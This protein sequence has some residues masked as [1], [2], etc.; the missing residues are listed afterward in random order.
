MDLSLNGNVRK[1]MALVRNSICILALMSTAYGAEVSKSSTELNP[2]PSKN[3]N[4]GFSSVLAS[5]LHRT[6]DIDHSLS[7]KFSITPSISLDGGYTF[8][9][10]LSGTKD[11]KGERKFHMGNGFIALSKGLRKFDNLS[12]SASLSAVIPLAEATKDIQ[13]L[14]TG[15]KLSPKFSYKATENSSLSYS[16]GIKI[17]FHEYKTSLVGTSNTQYSLSQSA[18]YNYNAWDLFSISLG[19]SYARSFTYNGNSKDFYSLSQSISF[20]P[21]DATG[22]EV[23]HSIGGNPLSANGTDSDINI[24]NSRESGVYAGFSFTY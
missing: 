5:S 19:G 22:I 7:N 10:G 24:F 6:S 17:N 23:G 21:S 12:I 20:A 1:N 18:S 2:A 11:L 16:P 8:I 4:I 13:T 15:I 14:R 9:A 3:Y